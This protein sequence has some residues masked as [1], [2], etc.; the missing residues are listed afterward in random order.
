VKPCNA[1]GTSQTKNQKE[2]KRF[3]NTPHFLTKPVRQE[4]RMSRWKKLV[5]TSI[6][7]GGNV[8]T[9][10][11]KEGQL[12]WNGSPNRAHGCLNPA[13]WES[14]AAKKATGVGTRS[15][16]SKCFHQNIRKEKKTPRA[17]GGNRR[18]HKPVSDQK[19]PEEERYSGLTDAECSK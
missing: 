4:K 12:K 1:K 14:T 11:E 19:T 6:F 15:N 5:N 8:C 16:G 10:I 3:Q 18:R 17:G 7:S 13:F 9:K 2:N